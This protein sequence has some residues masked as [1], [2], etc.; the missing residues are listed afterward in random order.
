MTRNNFTKATQR[1]ADPVGIFFAD[2]RKFGGKRALARDLHNDRRR[3]FRLRQYELAAAGAWCL[4]LALCVGAAYFAPF[5]VLFFT[6]AEREARR[7]RA[8]G[9]YWQCRRSIEVIGI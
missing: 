8:C 7:H 6:T 1:E 4:I 2:L 3:E 5:V 9:R